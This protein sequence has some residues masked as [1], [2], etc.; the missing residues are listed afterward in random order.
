MTSPNPTMDPPTAATAPFFRIFNGLSLPAVD[1]LAASSSAAISSPLFT[2][3]RVN[4]VSHSMSSSSGFGG[5]DSGFSVS[6]TSSAVVS[7]SLGTSVSSSFG[8]TVSSDVSFCCVGIDSSGASSD[9]L[10]GVIVV[11]SAVVFSEVSI[12]SF[13][14]SI[15]P[16]SKTLIASFS[17]VREF[18]GMTASLQTSFATLVVNGTLQLVS[19]DTTSVMATCGVSTDGDMVLYVV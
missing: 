6:V 18:V 8:T 7:S 4:G 13:S 16:L 5:F 10:S 11:S 15:G 12:T 2:F 14:D 17:S 1:T 19:L 3:G 9:S